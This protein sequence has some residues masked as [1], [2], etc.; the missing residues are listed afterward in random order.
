M[1]SSNP[2]GEPTTLTK[3]KGG[4]LSVDNAGEGARIPSTSKGGTMN[5]GIKEG[6]QQVREN[7]EQ[8]G[9]RRITPSKKELDGKTKKNQI[10]S[11]TRRAHITSA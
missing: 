3:S 4:M 1:Q 11:F 5:T 2:R 6:I 9:V 7:K 10:R 8:S